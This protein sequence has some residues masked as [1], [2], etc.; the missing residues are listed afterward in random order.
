M[1]EIRSI[2]LIGRTGN[3]KST[4]ANVITGTNEFKESDKGVSETKEAQVE[5]IE[6][7]GVEYRVVDTIGIGDTQWSAKEVLYRIGETVWMVKEGINQV[8]FVTSGRFTKEEK[9][10]YNLL[11]TVIFDEDIVRYTT[12]VRTNFPSFKKPERAAADKEALIKENKDMEYII[13]KCNNFIHVNN[14][15]IDTGDEREEEFG[16]ERRKESRE[17][18]LTH[19]YV[20]CKEIYNPGNLEE[21]NERIG[22]YMDEAE[23]NQKAIDEFKELIE[24]Q[25][26]KAY[27]ERQ[28]MLQEQEKHRLAHE[29]EMRELAQQQERERRENME[30]LER[31]YEEKRKM[32]AEKEELLRRMEQKK[33]DR[34]EQLSAK[35]ERQKQ[36]KGQEINDYTERVKKM[37]N[38]F[39]VKERESE[40]RIKELLNIVKSKEREM[41]RLEV[42]VSK[43][44]KEA[45]GE[46]AVRNEEMAVQNK[47]LVEQLTKDKGGCTMQ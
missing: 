42:D 8:L 31:E 47:Y 22:E 17:I 41:E 16:R 4:L 36:D 10:A 29:K 38:L 15:P 20:K 5:I 21:M 45:L 9:D 6:E 12:I 44:V 28:E 27:E 30:R 2:L 46:M 34:M 13:K 43:Q 18:L 3:G 37:E 26:R 24:Q 19:L 39:E 25:Q 1:T 11:R 33:N 40:S 23:K 7:E 35:H 14:P 32:V